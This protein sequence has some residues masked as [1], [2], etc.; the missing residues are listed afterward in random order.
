MVLKAL[1]VF[2]PPLT[3]SSS[4][5][6]ASPSLTL[7]LCGTRML[8]NLP[9][10]SSSSSSAPPYQ[11]RENRRTLLT[12][13]KMGVNGQYENEIGS[14]EANIKRKVQ[15]RQVQTNIEDTFSFQKST[16]LSW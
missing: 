15:S 4:A 2:L 3:S 1:L 16:F 13:Y 11:L 10:S 12:C 5:S 6:V 7:S 14:K 9:L 8:G